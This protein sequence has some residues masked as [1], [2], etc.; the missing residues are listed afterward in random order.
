M[1]HIIF[2]L[3]VIQSNLSLA[4]W[5][6][7]RKNSYVHLYHDSSTIVKEGDVVKMYVMASYAEPQI[8]PVTRKKYSSSVS[9]MG[10][11]CKQMK[12]VPLRS[13]TWS[14]KMATGDILDS[15]DLDTIKNSEAWWIDVVPD[16]TPY[17]RMKIAC[18]KYF[19]Y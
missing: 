16:T 10:F 8:D 14:G 12:S 18:K 5:E 4:D 2:L 1:K 19:E 7:T 15:F 6:V 11:R 17:D 3:L 13:R 9:L